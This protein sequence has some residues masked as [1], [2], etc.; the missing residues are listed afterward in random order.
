MPSQKVE[1]LKESP[2]VARSSNGSEG[3]AQST[4]STGRR[5]EGNGNWK[6]RTE[7]T[8]ALLSP[9]QLQAAHLLHERARL[10]IPELA[11][12]GYQEWGYSSVHSA[13]VALYRLFRRYDY[14]PR[15]R[16]EANRL[17]ASDESLRCAGE[18]IH[19]K[20]CRRPVMINSSYCPYHRASKTEAEVPQ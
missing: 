12:R 16:A 14:P 1:P 20:R 6:P 15:P 11:R 9:K 17:R 7:P 5:A 4:S 19:G 2:G 18:T 10:S 3:A 8:H 13:T